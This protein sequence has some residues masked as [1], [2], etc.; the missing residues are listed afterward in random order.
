[1]KI[2]EVMQYLEDIAPL[3]L[4]EPY[5]NAGLLIGNAGDACTG[6]IITL[7]VTEQ[8]ICEA[9]QKKCNLIVAHHPIIF[10]GLKKINGKNYVERAVVAAIKN[11]IAVYAIHTNLDNVENGV[12]RKIAEKLDL[13]NIKVLSPK[14]G[15]LR[16]LATFCPQKSAEKIRNALFGAGAGKVGNYGECSFNVKGIGTFKAGEG[17]RPFVG[18]VGE[19]HKENEVRIE[20]IFPFY[21][22]DQIVRSLKEA[23]PY[24]E[25]AY[26]IIELA[27]QYN[28]IGSGM[29]G[30]FPQPVSEKE[31]LSRLKAAF[32]TGVIRHTAFLH[33][34]IA[35]AAICGGL[36]VFCFRLQ[37]R[38]GRGPI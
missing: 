25:V 32:G 24:E 33:Q 6:I 10:K 36:A 12:N 26:D 14:E 4:Q 22:Q 21:L 18:E 28:A 37:K 34:K 38:T 5:D 30:D 20:V 19:R 27:N 1:M 15:T 23:H 13:Q 11:D 16:K 35:K 8:V 3:S 7:D 17:T 31:L 2:S 9:T 29:I